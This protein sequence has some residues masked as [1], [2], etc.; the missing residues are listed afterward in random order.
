MQTQLDYFLIDNP[1][2]LAEMSDA[3]RSRPEIPVAFD[4]ETT[5]L[6]FLS[7]R[8]I[9]L[10]FMQFG[11]A[12][13]IVDV[14]RWGREMLQSAGYILQDLFNDCQI[15]GVNLSFDWKF[16][17]RHTCAKIGNCYDVMLAEQVI[18]GLGMTG[19]R[20]VGVEFNLKAIAGR[21][22]IPVSK[23][24]RNIFIKMDQNPELWN[25][26][27]SDETLSYA[28]QDVEVL[29]KIFSAQSLQLQ[30]L[31][32]GHVCRLESRC[33][34]AAASIEYNGIHVNESGWR[35]VIAEKAETAKKLE[36]EAIEVFG[37]AIVRVRARE[38]RSAMRAY[39]AWK[40]AL[41]AKEAAVKAAFEAT[42]EKTGWGAF[43]KAEMAEWRALNPNPGQPKLSS[44]SP[45]AEWFEQW[46][47]YRKSIDI[48][49]LEEQEA[50]DFHVGQMMRVWEADH[51]KP[52]EDDYLESLYKQRRLCYEP[53]NLGSPKQLLDAFK[54]LGIPLQ[55]TSAEA[56]ADLPEG[57][58]PEVDLLKAWREANMFPVKFGDRLLANIHPVTG[59]IHPNLI[60]I[61]ADTGRMSVSNPLSKRGVA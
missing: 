59:R 56:I 7:D 52:A 19:G 41:E 53:I 61:G 49:G 2:D 8:L 14:R 55:S 44:H 47:R 39:N 23:E 5:G 46:E 37:E 30:E 36:Q 42:G 60:Q 29:E 11:Y 15:V 6:D 9:T 20:A 35:E 50:I 57:V 25:A 4:T 40:K 22:G 45:L 17:K 32:L 34:P 16:I 27:F 18:R 58:Y 10:Q 24:E 13:V 31:K 43:K 33:L 26:P 3:F 38:F 1:T 48:E 12:P 21:Y 51:P 54:E 28:A